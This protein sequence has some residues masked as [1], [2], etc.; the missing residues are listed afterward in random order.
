MKDLTWALAIAISVA[1]S[2]FSG[3]AFADD[4]GR[5][6]V[7]NFLVHVDQLDSIDAATRDEIKSMVR[8][9]T[10]DEYSQIE[11]IT[12]GLARIYPEYDKAI[13]ASQSDDAEQARKAL[14][15]F[16]P[17]LESEDPFLA[18]DSSF[19]LARILMNLQRHEEAI[20]IL[21]RLSGDLGRYTMHAGAALYFAGVA[22]ANLLENQRA[23]QSFSGFLDQYP[24]AP[25]RLRVAAWRQLQTIKAIQEGSLEDV[26]QR[27]DYSHRRLQIENT[28]DATQ[29]QQKNIVTMLQTM[30]QEEEKKE[31]SNCSGKGNTEKQEESQQQGEKDNKSDKEGKS[32]QG[33]SSN[34]P[35]GTVKRTFD[36]G[37]ASPWSRLRERSRDAANN[38]I[39][40]KLPSRY[41]NVVEKYYETI[42]GNEVK[43]EK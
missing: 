4:T 37:P 15:A 14:G 5:D 1:V 29:G 8:E 28:D 42:S 19:F 16:G 40:Q 9:M 24:D 11:A 3:K 25:E 30:I 18:A 34:N 12:S 21:E 6:V 2:V 23:I 13:L 20:P 43:G 27:M 31:C 10:A 17:F 22:Q 41:R 33:G 32:N 35:N 36:D 26:M 38:A 7:D 39:K